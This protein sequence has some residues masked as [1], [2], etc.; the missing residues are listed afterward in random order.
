[1][2]TTRQPRAAQLTRASARASPPSAASG[3]A[4]AKTRAAPRRGGDAARVRGGDDDAPGAGLDRRARRT[5]RRPRARPRARRRGRPVRPRESTIARAGRS[6]G[7][8]R[9]SPDDEPGAAGG[10]DLGGRELDH[11]ARR[12]ERAQRLARD[13]AV[14]ERHLAARL[15]LLSLLVALARDQHH[16]ARAARAPPLARSRARRSGSTSSAEPAP[17]RS[18]R[19][20]PS[21]IA[22]MIASGSSER[23]LSRRHDDVVGEAPRDGAHQRPLLAVAVAAG[24]EDADQPPAAALR[25][26]LARRRAARSRASPA[27]ARS[28][29]AREA[30]AL[31]DRLE[32]PGHARRPGERR[33]PRRATP[34]RARRAAASAPSAL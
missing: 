7:R 28:R 33:G 8:A 10:R 32:A 27:C 5:R 2:P 22:A 20:A 23:G 31:V 3:S 15:E 34:R 19:S 25:Q 30:L 17:A 26:Q 1:M 16:V 21:T 13:L 6:P 4:A 29:P 24:A 9:A 18:A 14:V 11:A 12:A